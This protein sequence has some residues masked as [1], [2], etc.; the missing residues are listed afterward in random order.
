MTR[1]PRG[2]PALVA[3]LGFAAFAAGPANA[4]VMRQKVVTRH[5]AT[6]HGVTLKRH[7]PVSAYNFPKYID[8]GTD[9]NPGGDNQYF[10]NTRS[11]SVFNGPT[12]TGPAYFQ[13]WWTTTY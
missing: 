13:R 5:H 9:Y 2:V 8:R 11:P 3:L 1:L 7:A 6:R 4:K 12:L 10:S